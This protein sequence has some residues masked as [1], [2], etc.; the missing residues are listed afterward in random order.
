MTK[1]EILKLIE[2]L[3]EDPNKIPSNFFKYEPHEVVEL[4]ELMI[5]RYKPALPPND[6]RYFT[7]NI[8]ADL[9]RFKD[10]LGGAP[11]FQGGVVTLNSDD[12][13]HHFMGQPLAAVKDWFRKTLNEGWRPV[14]FWN[15]VATYFHVTIGGQTQYENTHERIQR[16]GLLH[17]NREQINEILD[18]EEANRYPE[19]GQITGLAWHPKDNHKSIE[20]EYM[21]MIVI[22]VRMSGT[23]LRKNKSYSSIHYC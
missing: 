5:E 7:K 18:S 6:G 11:N 21:D 1:Y 10:R 15:F 2:Q 23:K 12:A 3:P 13:N 19:F 8:L 4:I 9:D 22:W 20:K 16:F 17:A 14:K